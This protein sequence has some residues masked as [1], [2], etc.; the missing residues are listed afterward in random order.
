MIPLIG[1]AGWSGV[2][3]TSL[4]E[5]LI[6]IMIQRGKRV[7]AIKHCAHGTDYGHPSAGA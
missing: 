4:L 1:F 7:A 6:P 5:A 3:K 2:G